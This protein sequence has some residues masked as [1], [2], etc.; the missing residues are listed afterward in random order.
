MSHKE[1]EH[2]RG[3]PHKGTII[4]LILLVISVNLLFV[5]FGDYPEDNQIH[6]AVLLPFSGSMQEFGIEYARGVVHRLLLNQQKKR[7]RA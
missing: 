3:F 1:H 6:I 2:G 5:S 7:S 4:M